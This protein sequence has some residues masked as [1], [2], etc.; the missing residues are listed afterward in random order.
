V[1]IFVGNLS[2]QATQDGVRELFAQHDVRAQ[3]SFGDVDAALILRH[4]DYHDDVPMSAQ[5]TLAASEM[6]RAAEVNVRTR[7][8]AM[9]L[10]S[11]NGAT[12]RT[13]TIQ[14]VVEEGDK[15]A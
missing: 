4:T 11:R 7:E 2:F 5:H 9:L 12:L 3:F 10:E 1:K 8:Y 14:G 15:G 6:S 13:V